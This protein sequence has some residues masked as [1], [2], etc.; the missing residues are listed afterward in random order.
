MDSAL[1]LVARAQIFHEQHSAS[2]LRKSQ[3]IKYGFLLKLLCYIN[4]HLSS[5]SNS[6]L[7]DLIFR[8]RH[9]DSIKPDMLCCSN[10]LCLWNP[11]NKIWIFAEPLQIGSLHFGCSNEISLF[12]TNFFW[13]TKMFKHFYEKPNSVIG[14][15][16][17]KSTQR[18]LRREMG[19][20]EQ[21]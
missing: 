4:L 3:V 15:L 5:A 21:M 7:H 10:S 17:R 14:Y 2:H 19:E 20:G 12:K 11:S 16:H 6:T 18:R 8:Y 13:G 9:I 1:D